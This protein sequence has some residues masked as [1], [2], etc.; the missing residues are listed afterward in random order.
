VMAY[1]A[2]RTNHPQWSIDVAQAAAGTY[3]SVYDGCGNWPFNVAFAS[4]HGL[5]GWVERLRGLSDIERYITQDM[6]VIASIKVAQGELD[7]SPYPKTDGHLLVVRGFTA[8]GDIIVNDPAGRPGTIRRIYKR[9]QFEHV[10]MNGSHGIV[11]VIGPPDL[12][13]TM[14]P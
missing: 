8:D 7:G 9:G 10:W 6:P 11:Y 12:L 2:A 14:R 5:A 3:D 1:W 13:K 4:E